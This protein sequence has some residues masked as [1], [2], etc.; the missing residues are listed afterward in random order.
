VLHVGCAGA[1]AICRDGRVISL[2]Y[3]GRELRDLMLS[4]VSFTL[5]LNVFML[6]VHNN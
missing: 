1:K 4:Q 3:D 6:S 5:L 2:S